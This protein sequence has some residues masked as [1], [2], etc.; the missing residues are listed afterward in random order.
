M[1]LDIRTARPDDAAA[2]QTIYAPMVEHTVISFETEV[3]SVED[4]EGRI[5]KTLQTHPYLVAE[6]EGQFSGFA[7]AGPHRT[8]GAYR[9][10][11]DVTVY[12]AEAVRGMGAGKALYRVLFDKLAEAGYHAAFAGITLPNPASEALHRSAGF[13]PV[14]IYKE[15]GFK[16]GTWHDVRWW[17]RLVDGPAAPPID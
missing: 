8:R 5:R 9:L 17:Q 12:V 1:P 7:Y 4:I 11:V 3:P 2:I 6:H 10:S 16:F 15:V 14:G 13:E